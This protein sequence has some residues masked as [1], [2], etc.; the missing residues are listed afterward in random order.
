MLGSVNCLKV[1]GPGK[2]EM[3]VILGCWDFD[4]SESLGCWQ[5][6]TPGSSKCWKFGSGTGTGTGSFEREALEALEQEAL[7]CW[8]I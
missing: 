7:E 8:R 5:V 1:G 3:F 6:R 4:M 2:F